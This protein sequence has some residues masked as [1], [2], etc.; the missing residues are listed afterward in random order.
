MLELRRP[1]RHHRG[2]QWYKLKVKKRK[3]FLSRIHKPVTKVVP[4]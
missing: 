3:G 4:H 2:Y 1:N